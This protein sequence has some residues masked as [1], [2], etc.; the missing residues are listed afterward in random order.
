[1]KQGIGYRWQEQQRSLLFLVPRPQFAFIRFDS[2]LN[3]FCSCSAVPCNLFNGFP[4][5][6]LSI[7]YS[8]LEHFF[9][10][11][12]RTTRRRMRFLVLL[13][14]VASLVVPPSASAASGRVRETSGFVF[15]SAFWPNL[16]HTL[17]AVAW[18][19]RPHTDKRVLAGP[20]P[21]PLEGALTADER[22]AWNAA[23]NYYDRE[24]ADRDLLFGDEM[25]GIKG[26]LAA[27][28]KTL[29]ET[30]L[31]PGLREVLLNAAPVYRRYWW[32][33]HDQ[34]NRAWIDDVAPRVAELAPSIIP[35]LSRLMQTPWFAQPARGRY[36][37]RRQNARRL[38]FFGS[39]AHHCFQREPDS[40]AMGWG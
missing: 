23:V 8:Y 27:A 16:H 20:L 7:M 30:G 3:R 40:A 9:I 2:R 19:R 4:H 36:C 39:C 26:L 32:P 31:P 34:A 29:P 13:C 21:E 14:T 24:L 5:F 38:H 10:Q 25:S 28:E 11:D 33:M 1:M 22:A 35:R 6:N 37:P 15:Y 12:A 17:Y 18:A